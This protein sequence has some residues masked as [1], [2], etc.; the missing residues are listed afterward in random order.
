[1]S[2]KLRILALLL[3]I[4]ALFAAC[5]KEE[6]APCPPE[7]EPAPE[8]DVRFNLNEVPYPKL[9]DYRFFVDTMVQLHPN[10]GV[11]P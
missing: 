1:M 7:E 10:S 4:T 9:S 2:W 3:L 6:E 11:L 8:T 5:R